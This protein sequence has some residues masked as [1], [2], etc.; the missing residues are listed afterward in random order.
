MSAPKK[1]PKDEV[2]KARRVTTMAATSQDV[3]QLPDFLE[4]TTQLQAIAETFHG[5]TDAELCE[6]KGVQLRSDMKALMPRLQA[7][8]RK[9]PLVVSPSSLTEDNTE[10]LLT[11]KTI[12][13]DGYGLIERY[14]VLA[15]DIPAKI[16]AAKKAFTA[17]ESEAPVSLLKCSKC[18]KQ[19]SGPLVELFGRQYHQGEKQPP[20]TST[21][22]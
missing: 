19:L 17:D 4:V 7:V 5:A 8:S 14:N 21:A 15:K 18:H 3:T 6:G 20:I 16:A 2:M 1:A 10:K 12:M 11:S 22:K 9:Y 13:Q